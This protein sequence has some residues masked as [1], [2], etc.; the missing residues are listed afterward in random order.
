[1]DANDLLETN[2]TAGALL[3]DAELELVKRKE[4]PVDL[5]TIPLEQWDNYIGRDVVL[6]AII[7]EWLDARPPA[8]I[9]ETFVQQAEEFTEQHHDV[10]TPYYLTMSLTLQ[11]T[12]RAWAYVPEAAPYL[13]G[14]TLQRTCSHDLH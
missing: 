1:M 13:T 3:R 5:R 6:P 2:K 9:D 8:A 7:K 14:L 10:K 4:P 12:G 11:Q